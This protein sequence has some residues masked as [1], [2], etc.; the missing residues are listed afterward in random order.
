MYP[1]SLVRRWRVPVILLASILTLAA[2]GGGGDDTGSAGDGAAAAGAGEVTIEGFNFVP[3]TIEVPTGT[4]VTW[5]NKDT[6]AHTVVD[7]GLFESEEL[8]QGATFSFTFDTPGEYS[9][10]CGIHPYMT[11]TVTVT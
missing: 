9:Y 4:A 6:A 10:I 2:C 7:E 1:I 3:E 8:D 11:A 5:T